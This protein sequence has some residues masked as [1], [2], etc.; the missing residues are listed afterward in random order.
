MI[1]QIVKSGAGLPH[2]KAEGADGETKEK[3]VRGVPKA[4]KER[5]KRKKAKTFDDNTTPRKSN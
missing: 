3:N 4:A 2:N 5:E 1:K